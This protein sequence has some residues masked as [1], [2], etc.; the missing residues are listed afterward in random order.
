MANIAPHGDGWRAQVAKRGVRKSKVFR[1]KAEAKLWAARLEVEIDSAKGELGHTF[2][3]AAK[4]Y[5]EEVTPTKRG[6]RWEEMRMRAFLNHPALDKRLSELDDACIKAWRDDR[7]KT[8]KTSTLLREVNLLRNVFTVARD[9]WKWM[10]GNPFT[11]V[12]LP[13]DSPPRDAIWGWREIRKVLR[14]K[15]ADSPM[16]AEMID[17]FHIALRTGMR[18]Q[19][20]LM[21]PENFDPVRRVVTLPKSKTSTLPSHVPIG[22]IAAKLLA[23][24]PFTV[25][26]NTGSTL[27]TR[28]TRSLGIVGLTFHDSRAAALTYLSR[29]VDVLTLARISRHKDVRLLSAVYY[30]ATPESIAKLI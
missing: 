1:T 27:F 16:T 28:L 8:V 29:K 6:K 25:D 30:R 19:E 18:L 12:K 13:P 15:R 3:Q 9:E 11:G 24:P 26:P 21:A 22:R 4:K 7:L 20:V 14:A 10:N 2:R 17:A 23:R 5:L